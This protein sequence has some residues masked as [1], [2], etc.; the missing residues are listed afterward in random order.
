MGW[1][2]ASASA[3]GSTSSDVVTAL[4]AAAR[5]R[6]LDIAVGLTL[7]ADNEMVGPALA[8]PAASADVTSLR[9]PTELRAAAGRS[10]GC[11]M[12]SEVRPRP[13]YC[14]GPGNYEEVE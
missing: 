11:G 12:D 4:S 14:L 8:L 1:H 10:G 7:E 9:L 2:A 3:A 6:G 5:R 13:A